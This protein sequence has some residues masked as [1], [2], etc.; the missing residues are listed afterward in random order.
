M[1]ANANEG[2][3]VFTMLTLDWSDDYAVDSGVIDAEHKSLFA[4]ANR[5]FRISDPITRR[6]EI[7]A[8]VKALVQYMEGHFQHEEELM[9]RC[10]YP[11]LLEHIEMHRQIATGLARAVREIKDIQH[12]A[13]ELRFIMVEWVLAAHSP[14]GQSGR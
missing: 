4:I 11:A 1:A 6:D 9:M 3:E 14:Y 7:T 13:A 2:C 5:V 12:F 10:E 8:A